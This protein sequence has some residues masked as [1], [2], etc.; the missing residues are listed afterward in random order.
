MS[1]SL[2]LWLG[3]SLLCVGLVIPQSVASGGIIASE[4][5][6]YTAGNSLEGM[7]GA[8]DGWEEAWPTPL[9]V[10]VVSPGL[11]YVDSKGNMLV[12]GGN[13]IRTAFHPDGNAFRAIDLSP[14]S[15]ADLLGVVDPVTGKLGRDGTTL[16]LSFLAASTA[17][18]G[19]TPDLHWGGFNL[20]DGN[21]EK[22]FLGKKADEAFVWSAFEIGGDTEL[23]ATPTTEQAFF[24]AS[25]DFSAGGE[26]LHVWLNP[27]LDQTPSLGDADISLAVGNFQ[28]DRIRF[29]GS[30]LFTFDELRIG[31]TYGSVSPFTAPVPEP[32]T[33]LQFVLLLASL[34]LVRIAQ[35]SRFAAWMNTPPEGR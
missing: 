32:S 35:T 21:D 12:S 18:P 20:F 3:V 11:S 10:Q 22:I 1:R 24:V 13:A 29:A 23:T 25:I 5:F 2:R 6:N 7:G 26:T 28:F 27:D 14:G 8:V 16:W 9:A 15:N 34:G 30:D 33:L 31:T 19:T 4:S 17:V